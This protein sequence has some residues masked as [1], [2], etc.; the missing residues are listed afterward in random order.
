[1]ISIRESAGAC[2]FAIRVQPRARRNEIVG[3][4]GDALKIAITAPPVEG[5]ANAACIELLAKALKVPRSSVSIAAGETSR[6]KLV[7]V[8][9]LTANEIR[10]RLTEENTNEP[11]RR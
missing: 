6:N 11:R 3:K 10:D 8:V 2:T 5:K 1:M 7:R 4:I 9:G